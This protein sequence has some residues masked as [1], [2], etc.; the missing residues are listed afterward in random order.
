MVDLGCEDW[1]GRAIPGRR[2]G[3]SETRGQAHCRGVTGD[4]REE[5]AVRPKWA[6]RGR[7]SSSRSQK[8]DGVAEAEGAGFGLVGEIQ[9]EV[10]AG[11]IGGV[12]AVGRERAE[13]FVGAFA[14]ELIRGDDGAS[15]AGAAAAKRDGANADAGPGVLR[16]RGA[17]ADDKRRAEAINGDR[18][19]ADGDEAV[20]EVRERGFAHDEEGIAIGEIKEIG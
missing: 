10:D 20:V 19:F 18:F 7:W 6:G 17:A 14:G 12:A 2:H 16:E 1:R 3:W 8:L 15:G 11:R 4:R 13:G 5:E 9:G